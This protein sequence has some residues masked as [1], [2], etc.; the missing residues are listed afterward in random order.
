MSKIM[1]VYYDNAGLPYKDSALSTLYPIVGSEFTGANNTTEIHFYTENMGQATWVANCLLPNGDKLNRLLLQGVDGDGLI[2]QNL[3][4]DRE[5]TSI[6][7]HLKIGLNGYAGNISIDEEEL[8]EN[9]LV[10]ISGTPTIIATGIIDIAMNYSPIV[11]P[12]SE[13]EPNEY[14]ELLALMGTKLNIS[15]GILVLNDISLTSASDYNNGQLVYDKET[16]LFYI[17]N[18]GA[19]E[20]ENIDIGEIEINGEKL[21][22]I[23][24]NKLDKTTTPLRLYG[25]DS[26]GNQ[27][28]YSIDEF[29]QEIANVPSKQMTIT[30]LGAD[31]IT[32]INGKSLLGSGYDYI[33]STGYYTITYNGQNLT[34]EL[35]RNYMEHMC[36]SRYLPTYDYNYP[37]NTYFITNIG[38]FLK[39]EFS[40]A[41]GLRLYSLEENTF[42]LVDNKTTILSPSSTN[43]QYPGAKA[44]YDSVQNV[45][46]VAEGKCKSFVLSYNDTIAALKQIVT[47]IPPLYNPITN[48]IYTYDSNGEL[49]DISVDVANGDYDNYQYQNSLF[50]SQ[51]ASISNVDGYIIIRSYSVGRYILLP[52]PYQQEIIK[53]GDLFY[54]IETDVPDRWYA[55]G[56]TPASFFKLETSKVD[57]TN[58]YSKASDIISNCDLGYDIGSADCRFGDLYLGGS[59][60]VGDSSHYI[61]ESSNGFEFTD[62]IVPTTSENKDLGA[63]TR[64]WNNVWTNNLKGI[65]TITQAQYDALVSGGTIDSNQIYFIEEE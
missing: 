5:L 22:D 4:L 14:Q 29:E 12:I 54:V 45:R 62:N 15:N 23:L 16:K 59:I 63:Q 24:N 41:N 47:P 50:N 17:V 44:V 8:E 31:I 61:I 10:V 57:L 40:V 3:P 48:V 30:K 27:K 43:Q 33:S 1:R 36:G 32:N 37:K 21:V 58:Y 34:E 35:A 52:M 25:T 28:L 60:F 7:G 65:V 49:V 6:K 55:G 19:F 39:P 20:I 42:E 11:I 13:L 18:N 9:D 64:K 53:L 46:E 26:S 56:K 2:Y 38:N 51:N